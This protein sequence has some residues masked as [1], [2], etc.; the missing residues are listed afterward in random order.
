M[1]TTKG[2]GASEGKGNDEGKGKEGK[3]SGKGEGGLTA[4]E[5]AAMRAAIKERKSK[6]DGESQIQEAIQEMSADDK[7]RALRLHAIIKEN[8]PTLTP[9]TWY[10]MPAYANKDEDVVVFFRA[11]GK[12]KERYMTLGF[13][14]AAALDDGNLW[15]TSYAITEL[16][17]AEEKRIAALVRKA[18]G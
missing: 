17:A 7:R 12:F 9:K 14:P 8:A 18:A 6:L 1:A 11:A 2:K 15:A 5:K 4:A 3:G 16:T 13:Q 10:G